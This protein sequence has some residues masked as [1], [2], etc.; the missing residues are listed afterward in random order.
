MV[1]KLNLNFLVD[2]FLETFQKRVIL[3]VHALS[4]HSRVNLKLLVA[5]LIQMVLFFEAAIAHCLERVDPLLCLG[6]VLAQESVALFLE[7]HVELP[8]VLGV[9]V[10][11]LGQLYINMLYSFSCSFMSVPVKHAALES[12]VLFDMLD[13]NSVSECLKPHL[14]PT[15]YSA[16]HH[17][18]QVSL[19]PL[20]SF[21]PRH[22]HTGLVQVAAHPLVRLSA[23][24]R[25][26]RLLGV[27]L[28][29][30]FLGALDF[31]LFSTPSLE[32][33]APL[34]KEIVHVKAASF[35]FLV[36]LDSRQLIFFGGR[37]L[38]LGGVQVLENADPA[39]TLVKL[40]VFLEFF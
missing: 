3:G 37:C 32:V 20:A 5:V 1:Q 10:Y 16:K 12:E 31:F 27:S 8:W 36:M 19:A 28:T 26:L 4:G 13:L 11:R 40:R 34:L 9:Q 22:L 33:D 17:S 7:D 39:V 38:S 6:F 18:K 23:V 29:R 15:S 30:I 2:T 14:E 25:Y 24:N 21:T 35:I